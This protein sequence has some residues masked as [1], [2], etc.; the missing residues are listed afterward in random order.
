MW[1]PSFFD[2][3]SAYKHMHVNLKIH[4]PKAQLLYPRE[5]VDY[6]FM[7]IG[8]INIRDKFVHILP[9]RHAKWIYLFAG[10]ISKSS[11]RQGLQ[12]ITKHTCGDFAR[13][14]SLVCWFLW[15]GKNH[16]AL[17]PPCCHSS[18]RLVSKFT[19]SD[20]RHT[21]ELIPLLAKPDRCWSWLVVEL[22]PTRYYRI[23]RGWI[24]NLT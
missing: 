19:H 1:E 11:R 22:C 24:M 2:F 23:V 5:N 8:L 18:R 20:D 6:N 10:S 14:W 9:V 17:S 15:N 21:V 4:N 13:K 12:A 7:S 16:A 3:T